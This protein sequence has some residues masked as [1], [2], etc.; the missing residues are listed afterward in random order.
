MNLAPIPMVETQVAFNAARS[1]M[2]GAELNIYETIGKGSLTAEDIS[3]ICHTHAKA[4]KQLLD[5]LVGLGY[6]SWSDNKYSLKSRYYKWLLKEYES[7]IISKLRFQIYEWD[8]M[9][10]LEDYVRTGKSIDIHSTSS[11]EIW[12]SYQ[13]GMRDLSVNSTKEVAGKI[14]LPSG[15]TQLL[16]IGG[17][18]GLYSIELCKKH[19]DLSATIL[20]LPD[21]IEAASAIG[22]KYDTTGR[23]NYKAGN[24]LQD[25]LGKEVYDAVM[26]NNVVHHFT[27]EQ[28]K[29]LSKKIYSALKPNGI[30]LIGEFIRSDKP[31]EGGAV[32]ATLNLYFSLTSF[33]GTW[34]EKEME[35]W[36]KDAGMKVMKPVVP[37]SIPGFKMIVGKK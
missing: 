16:D 7:N 17:S 26:I 18:H 8:W 14:P 30:F 15:A 27:T 32:A 24:A 33:S 11:K 28:N 3:K 23:I 10:R 22:K 21:A 31:G 12:K 5:C 2:A 1:I 13:D 37:M 19:K 35:S 25:D 9:A 4:T 20:E 29:M 34:S 6:L 36:I